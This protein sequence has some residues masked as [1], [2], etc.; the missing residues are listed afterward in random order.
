MQNII[1]DKVQQWSAT[2]QGDIDYNAIHAL[3]EYLLKHRFEQYSPTYGA[4]PGFRRRLE[5]W[6][7]NNLSEQDQK[8]LFRLIPSIFFIGTDE[9]LALHR[10]TFRG[11]ILGNNLLG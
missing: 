11:P 8:L 3:I 6:L 9:F 4:K 10:A 1:S 7:D 5:L 2:E